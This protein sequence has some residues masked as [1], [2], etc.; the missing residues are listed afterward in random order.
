MAGAAWVYLG[1]LSATYP[2]E[3]CKAGAGEWFCERSVQDLRESGCGSVVDWRTDLFSAG[4]AISHAWVDVHSA[5]PAFPGW[6]GAR[7]LPGS[8]LSDAACDGSSGW[9]EMGYISSTGVA[10]CCAGRGFYRD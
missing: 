4:P 7:V 2:C 9:G 5:V 1:P 3:G 10:A 8:G 6:Q